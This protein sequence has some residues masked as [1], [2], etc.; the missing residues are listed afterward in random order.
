MVPYPPLVT[1]DTGLGS[2]YE[3]VV[4]Y[5]LIERWIA[6]HPVR[7]AME[8]VFDGMAGIPGLHLIPAARA[9]A[10]VTVVSPTEELAATVHGVYAYLGLTDRLRPVVSRE[11]PANESADL[12]MIFNA[13]AFVPD[14][15]AFLRRTASHCRR[16]LIISTTNPS[17]YG[18]FLCR[19][20]RAIGLKAR[21]TELFDHASTRTVD[22]EIQGFGT[23]V[24]RSYVDAPWW[25]DLFV[26]PGDSLISGTLR[27]LPRRRDTTPRP[28]ARSLRH[29]YGPDFYPYFGRDERERLL[30][31]DILRQPNADCSPARVLAP[32]FAHHRMLLAAVRN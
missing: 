32:V 8:G 18:A 17:C 30:V 23:I 26:K 31:R 2:A 11:W 15:P 6:A 7:T 3:R 10:T 20:L 19:G 27:S 5:R 25:P 28:S 9:G 12:V 21:E 1:R 13:L 4:I 29:T 24:E 14:W 16:H 22:R